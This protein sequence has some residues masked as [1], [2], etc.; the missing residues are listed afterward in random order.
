M[1]ESKSREE[2]RPGLFGF[3][4]VSSNYLPDSVSFFGSIHPAQP[5]SISPYQPLLITL[6]LSPFTHNKNVLNK[7]SSAFW[8][9]N[10]NSTINCCFF[11]KLALLQSIAWKWGLWFCKAFCLRIWVCLSLSRTTHLWFGIQF[12]FGLKFQSR[13]L[14]KFEPSWSAINNII[15]YLVNIFI[16]LFIDLFINNSKLYIENI[17]NQRSQ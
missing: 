17:Y 9:S 4:S 1:N 15:S 2:F 11:L 16:F 5:V 12:K 8:F 14:T 13:L 3:Y 10:K 7:T 6:P